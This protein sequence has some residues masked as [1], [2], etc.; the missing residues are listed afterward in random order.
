MKIPKL[1]AFFLLFSL[2]C[3]SQEI[4][5][6][7]TKL[8]IGNF[9]PEI[10]R[11]VSSPDNT[12]N[13]LVSV[14]G[15]NAKNRSAEINTYSSF[16][17]GKTFQLSLKSNSS[18]WVSE[19]ANAYG[20]N[21]NCYVIT[22]V[23]KRS[24]KFRGH[25]YGQMQLFHSKDGGKTWGNTVKSNFMDWTSA[26]VDNSKSIYSGRLYISAYDIANGSGDWIGPKKPLVFSTDKGLS[27]SKPVFTGKYPEDGGG[28][29]ISSKVDK[30]GTLYILYKRDIPSGI[31]IAKSKDGGQSLSMLP[32]ISKDSATSSRNI[33]GSEFDIDSNGRLYLSYSA[34]QKDKSVIILAYSDDEGFS[35]KNKVVT[36]YDS[37]KATGL[38]N[39][40]ITI[41]RNGLIGLFWYESKT[42]N[43][44]FSFSKSADSPFSTP[45]ILSNS[46]GFNFSNTQFLENHFQ[47]MGTFEPDDNSEEKRSALGLSVRIIPFSPALS[48]TSDLD[49]N[50]Q[51]FWTEQQTDG[52]PSL[53]NAKLSPVGKTD[54]QPPKKINTKNLVDLNEKVI[55]DIL[56]QQFNSSSGEITLDFTITNKSEQKIFTP[57]YIELSKLMTGYG[58]SDVE[59]LN[60]ADLFTENGN[61]VID[62]S[63]LVGNGELNSGV[64][65]S[66]YSISFKIR[67]TESTE[68]IWKKVQEAGE[69][70]HPI[71][72]KFNIFGLSSN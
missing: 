21:N 70:I 40:S 18:Q 35:W 3:Q 42:K 22:G 45:L 2:I 26:I 49:G 64:S 66:I 53:F 12:N 50:F 4:N 13:L 28:Y 9:V 31:L 24:G 61:S 23:S 41:N 39:V 33:F 11:S 16:D 52:S 56:H 62:M 44:K 68:N 34:V 20:F 8:D 72:C 27:I 29:P 38:G 19:V 43:Y 51:L 25:P 7:K 63:K 55:I 14:Y 1:L 60:K 46:S 54:E 5:I 32:V 58:Y 17:G 65:S 6:R 69:T 59:L 36:Y 47:T 10:I 15:W 37:D 30:K 71:I 48:M 57:I 67:Q